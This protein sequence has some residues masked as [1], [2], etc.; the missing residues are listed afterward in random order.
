MTTFGFEFEEVEPTDEELAEVL[1][2]EFEEFPE[3][4]E[5]LH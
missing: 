1:G 3:S 5:D 2:E 4:Y